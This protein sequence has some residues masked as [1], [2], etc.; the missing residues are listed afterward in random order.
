MVV[1]FSKISSDVFC[2]QNNGIALRKPNILVTGTPGTG[3]S[4]FCEFIRERLEGVVHV[5]L[6]QSIRNEK[7]YKEWDDD[8]ECSIFDEELV[9]DYLRD[10]YERQH[11]HGNVLVDFHTCECFDECW[12]D[13]VIVLKSD[14][15]ILYDRLQERGYSQTKIQKNVEC[16]I[17]QT[18][19]QEAQET[20]EETEVTVLDLQNDTTADLQQNMSKVLD[21]CAEWQLRQQEGQASSLRLQYDE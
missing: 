7:L 16:E 17:F 5:D 18:V 3:K 20:F 13:L 14:N 21:W 8:M 2:P 10:L 15:T 4:T 6:G 11:I 1:N 12:V 9:V 19:L